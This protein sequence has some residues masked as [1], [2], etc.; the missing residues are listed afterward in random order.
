VHDFTRVD[1]IYDQILAIGIRPVVELGFMPA[2]LARDSS[3]TVFGYRGIISPPSE[4]S[5]WHDLIRALAAHLVERYGIDEVAQWSFEVWNEP[6]LVVFWSGTQDEYFRLY[7]ETARAVKSVDARL[8]V[9]GPSTA[10]GDWVEGLT[11][12]AEAEGTALDF[13]TTHTY[14]NLPL[15]ERASL[16]RHGFEGIPIWWTEWGVGHTHFGPIHDS[17]FGAAFVLSGYASAQGRMEALAYWVV[18]DHFEELGR[19]PRLFH[20][21]FGLLTVG[22]LRKPRYWA[23]QLAAD[24]GDDVLASQVS[25]DGADVLVQSWASRHDDGSVDLLVWNG[26]VNAEVKDGDARLDRD[27]TVLV[28]GLTESAYAVEVNRIDE[29]HSNLPAECPDDVEWPD[30]ELWEQLRAKDVLDSQQLPDV[31]PTDGTIQHDFAL[32]MPGIIRLRLTPARPR[33]DEETN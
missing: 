17:V 25:G 20:N 1:E 29:T 13:L 9:G 30:A 16:A 23:V 3:E 22:N 11:A 21:G 15:D 10:A 18:S 7:D 6:N 14:G 28:S 32:P 31:H 5:E 19:P 33:T 8:R 24:L 2:C 27:V 26:T 4:W 12:H